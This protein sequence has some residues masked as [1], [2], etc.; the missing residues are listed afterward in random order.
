MAAARFWQYWRLS[1]RPRASRHATGRLGAFLESWVSIAWVWR[2]VSTWLGVK[3]G[4]LW[5]HPMIGVMVKASPAPYTPPHE[6]PI[7]NPFLSR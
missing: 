1:P 7:P 4:W 3:P 5:K 6:I 2:R